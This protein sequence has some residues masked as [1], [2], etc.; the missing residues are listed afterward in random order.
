MPQ[1]IG[2][3]TLGKRILSV[4]LL[5]S[6]VLELAGVFELPVLSAADEATPEAYVAL[7][8]L[9]VEQID[10]LRGEKMTLEAV[11]TS[12]EGLRYQW[13]IRHPAD[14]ERWIDVSDANGASLAFSHALVASLAD[15][16]G[17]VYLRCVMNGYEEYITSAVKVC[18]VSDVASSAAAFSMRSAAPSLLAQT[19]STGEE[20]GEGELRAHS[21]VINY[22]FDN[23]AIAFEPNGAAVAH[24][25]A[26]HETVK[27]PKVVGYAPFRRIGEDYVEAPEV[28]FDLAEVTEDITV[29]VI[30]E[31]ALVDFS[32]HHHL[33]NLHNDEYSL[34][35]DY[36]TTGRGLTGALV[37]EGLAFTETQRPGFKSLSYERLTIAA[38]GSTV[39][40]IRYD[41]N[42]YLVDFDMNGGYG[43]DPVYTRFGDSVGAN[44]PVRH[45]YVFDGWELVSYNG[46][47]P[48]EQQSSDYALAEGTTV[49]VPAAN[50]EYRARWITTQTTYTMVFWRE[51]AED[52]GYTYWDHLPGL[53]AVSGSLVD[54]QDLIGQ[55]SEIEDEENFTFNAEKTD[56]N[57][58]IEG[59][60]SSVVNVYYTRNYHKITLKAPGK[61][62]IPAGHTHTEACYDY[63]CGLGHTHTDACDPVLECTETLHPA[64]TDECLVCTTPEHSHSPVCTCPLTEHTHVKACWPDAGT[65]QNNA[66]SGA[67]SNPAD[68]TVFRRNTFST[69]YIYIK[70]TW[71]R[72]NGR[73]S[74]GVVVDPSCG[75]DTEHTHTDA[76][77]CKIMEHTH[78]LSCYSDTLHTHTESC[79]RYS[80]GAVGHE[81]TDACLRLKCGI[82]VG[83]THTTSCQSSTATNVVGEIYRKYQQSVADL[84][85]IVD[86]HGVVYN[87]GERW[88]PSD[89]T[90]FTQ[91]LV[92]ITEMPADSF[93]LTLD[94]ATHTPY[95]MQYYMELLPGQ[96]VEEGTEV[97]TLDGKRYALENTI[98][99]KYNY[100]TRAE[101]FFD[102]TGFTQYRSDP[103][104]DR[105]DQIDLSGDEE[106]LIVKFYYNRSNHDLHFKSHGEVLEDREQTG[107]LYGT[108]LKD[109]Y[110]VPDYPAT[111]E[112]NA[113]EFAGW[114]TSPGCYDGSEVDWDSLT[115][116]DGDLM[117]YAKWAPIK[118]RVRVWLD[119]SLT[120]PIG[121]EQ[122]VDHGAFAVAPSENVTNGNYSFQ[123]WFYTT[124]V[125]GER[126]E[127]AFN[128]TGI[129][130]LDDMDIYAKWGSHVSVEYRVNYVLQLTGEPVAD[131][132][133]GSALAGHNKTF[134]A[135][136]GADLYEKFRSGYYPLVSSHTITM[137]VDGTHEFT[138]YYVF[139][140][141]MPY[142]VRFVDAQTGES[143]LPEKKVMDNSLSVVTETFERMDKMIPDA[144]QK[145]LV[146]SANE[147][148]SDGDGIFDA[149]V[150][151]FYYRHDEVHAYYKVVH[152][153]QNIAADGY[154]EYQS[155]ETLGVIGEEY[156]ATPI[157]ITGFSFNAAAT[158]INGVVTPASATGVKAVLDQEGMIL[159]LYYDRIEYPY[160]VIYT[161][162]ETGEQ[163][164][165]PKRA[166]ALFGA[167]I[168]ERAADLREKG[169]TLSSDGVKLLSVSANE[170]HNVIEFLY[171]ES[172]VSIKYHMVGALGGGTLTRSSE[173]LSAV[174][175]VALG[176]AP[177]VSGGYYFDGWYL[178]ADCKSPVD[179]A[180]VD[181]ET[182]KLSPVKA[183]DAVWPEGLEFFARF[184]PKETKLTVMKSGWYPL[185]TDQAFLFCIRGVADTETEGIDLTFSI[186]ENGS[187]VLAGLPVGEYTVT[188]LVGWSWRYE[189]TEHEKRITLSVNPEDNVLVF[190]NTRDL[191][192]W[193]DG[194]A[195]RQNMFSE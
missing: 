1:K 68:G 179:A 81:H 62:T 124:V 195:F 46:H 24:G 3:K 22:L 94:K 149:N 171:L 71:Y 111:L 56:K 117:L 98:K 74:G 33:Q 186:K 167:Q 160:T 89:S 82:T 129:P 123:G 69:R 155:S 41:R 172:V 4:L 73:A 15:A 30:Y 137:S 58:I 148:D 140:P 35:A 99:A 2:R 165:P 164:L 133:E 87:N 166:T 105:N 122:I 178:D 7:D 92:F 113:Y 162:G 53:G 119:Q 96:T 151:T 83:H 139:V 59:D 9:P 185:D 72:Y 126:V 169:Y 21:I 77:D 104:F 88:K 48:T 64:H 130:V 141:A 65:R 50:L 100:V 54:G 19:D 150:I 145:R 153:L 128:F 39:V 143:I 190:S 90:V 14:T 16:S 108:P 177:L 49:T 78:G 32:V 118:H 75:F 76:C 47:L 28:V 115:M 11:C 45:G 120:E 27:S 95:T 61:C 109:Y 25:S 187:A 136:A 116:P 173:N 43:T 29:N 131:S 183:S 144:Y 44:T 20:P 18:L 42:Y 91:V 193:L 80:C 66:P 70:G 159:E 188:E 125:N 10:L 191:P 31:P 52:D 114:Y 158:R 170:S 67:P 184:L 79:Y 84:F 13:Q 176:S 142:A 135:K 152:Y 63:V 40:E 23:N 85:P 101:D 26:F 194:N 163:L 36:V 97:V 146:L 38:D 154:R 127:K 180:L 192:K 189:S 37:P 106:D 57:V 174:T 51:N 12:E 138:F 103:D 86:D 168:T 156:T 161:N 55:I 132:T 134:E 181:P 60:G 112:P 110:F 34:T 102:I 17:E 93:T 121:Q 157:T 107:V 6:V 182:G 147:L 5:L 8:G 175:G